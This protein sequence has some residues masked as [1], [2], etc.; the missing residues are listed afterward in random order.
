[1]SRRPQPD[2][3]MYDTDGNGKP[4]LKGL[5]RRGERDPYRYEKIKE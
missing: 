5:Y 2:L 3:A 4:D 1:M